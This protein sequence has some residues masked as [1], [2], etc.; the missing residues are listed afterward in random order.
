MDGAIVVGAQWGDEGKGKI[1]DFLSQDM[2]VVVRFNGG[3]NA[4]HTVFYNGRE[5]RLHQIPSGVLNGK[6][7]VLGNG[8]VIDPAELVSEI[9]NLA[10]IGIN[11][12]IFISDRATVIMPYH[13]EIDRAKGHGIGTTGRGIGPA[14][15]D[16]MERTNL[17]ICDITHPNAEDIISKGI[18]AKRD[19]LI[20]E[21]ITTSEGFDSYKEEIVDSYVAYGKQITQFVKS[22]SFLIDNFF[23]DS[24]KVLFEG[25]QGVLLDIDFG[26]YPFVTSSN[27]V[28]QGAF[29]GS[30]ASFSMVERIIGIT[31]AYTTR[32]G[33]GPFPTEIEGT[34]AVTLKEKGSEY[35]ATTG[36]PRR[37][38]Y[39]DLFALKYAVKVSGI[40]ELAVTKIDVLSSIPNLKIAVSYKLSGKQL[41]Y[42]PPN[43]D[44]L[45][46][47]M[48]IYET[49]EPLEFLEKTEWE[50]LKKLSKDMLPVSIR[51]YISFIEQFTGVPVT[52]LSYGPKRGD[53]IE[54]R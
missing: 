37:V 5:V 33:E 12:S 43:A 46:N 24:K 17:R 14:Y 34:D 10:S 50:T 41:E 30:G 35:G 27:T 2:D 45:K 6:V 16:K 8:M 28:A 38:G 25:A 31:K 11:P 48:P 23:K 42:F 21:G 1:V 40:K 20:F 51:K 13:K 15:Q 32:V 54:Y 36:R 4:G 39:L 29:T 22:A 52:I 47:V 26:T 7:C 9:E 53:T 18:D 3:A 44:D 19:Y 49:F